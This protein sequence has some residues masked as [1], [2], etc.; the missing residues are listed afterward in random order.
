MNKLSSHGDRNKRKKEMITS[1][2]DQIKMF[3]SEPYQKDS[4]KAQDIT[5]VVSVNN[6][7]TTLDEGHKKNWWHDQ[8]QS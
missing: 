8:S 3:T 7:H 6:K 1:T 2:M 4:P 5:T